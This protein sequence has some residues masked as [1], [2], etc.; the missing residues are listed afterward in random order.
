MKR[1]GL[2]DDKN[3]DKS[4]LVD[5]PLEDL[6]RACRTSR[7]M[8]N[9]CKD[10]NF[11]R[12]RVQ[13]IVPSIQN[14]G[15]P[16]KDYYFYL[17]I[18][19]RYGQ[20]LGNIRNVARQKPANVTPEEYY[21]WL[22]KFFEIVKIDEENYL[23]KILENY[24]SLYAL[25]FL[26][27][28]PGAYTWTNKYYEI[29]T[30]YYVELA[31][32]ELKEP[33]Y[34]FIPK[35]LRVAGREQDIRRYYLEAG[36]TQELVDQVIDAA[37][38]NPPVEQPVTVPSDLPDLKKIQGIIQEKVIMRQKLDEIERLL[39]ETIKGFANRETREGFVD[40]LRDYV[41]DLGAFVD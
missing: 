19:Q 2:T 12:L 31:E 40:H 37:R 23:S 34:I 35:N 14:P 6:Y 9:L 28:N 39:R 21:H 7:F 8:N 29:P 32:K 16:W 17:L 18:V 1:G 24:P 25:A 30:G 15:I 27:H 26:Y 5:L 38:N 33:D 22:N 20:F 11:W 3:L 13:K 36:Y 10:D 41:G 4:I